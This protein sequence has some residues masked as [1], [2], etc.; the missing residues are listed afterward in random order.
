VHA[1]DLDPDE[2]LGR[3]LRCRETEGELYGVHRIDDQWTQV[4][5]L[6]RGMPPLVVALPAGLPVELNPP[7]T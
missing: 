1:H 4:I 7:R 3:Y 2:D 6:R 5:V